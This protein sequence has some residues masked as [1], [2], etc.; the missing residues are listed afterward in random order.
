[1]K[2]NGKK[3]WKH[4]CFRPSWALKWP[5]TKSAYSCRGRHLVCSEP[6]CHVRHGHRYSS[7]ASVQNIQIRMLKATMD[8]KF[9]G[10]K[11]RNCGEMMASIE[12]GQRHNIWWGT[13]FTCSLPL[14][15]KRKQ[16][17]ATFLK[18]CSQIYYGIH[19]HNIGFTQVSFMIAP[20]TQSSRD[21]RPSKENRLI[22]QVTKNKFSGNV[23]VMGPLLW[24]NLDKDCNIY[25][26]V[27]ENLEAIPIYEGLQL[28]LKYI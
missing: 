21:T 23:S 27:F 8:T 16:T 17:S 10:C 28:V 19:S 22:K 3:P 6:M 7:P 25:W 18:L 14:L 11:K 5:L 12:Q 1:M 26:K 13:P 20:D 9:D 24:N 15:L 2:V 4:N